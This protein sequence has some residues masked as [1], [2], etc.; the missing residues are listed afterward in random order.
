MKETCGKLF[1]KPWPGTLVENVDVY[2]GK[3]F[4]F[5]KK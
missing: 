1:F 2:D 5:I 3:Y 4:S